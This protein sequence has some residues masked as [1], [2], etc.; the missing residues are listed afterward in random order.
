MA[1]ASVNKKEPLNQC[2]N[3]L[4]IAPYSVWR[5]IAMRKPLMSISRIKPPLAG[6]QYYYSIQKSSHPRFLRKKKFN[7]NGTASVGLI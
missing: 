4:A 7:Q 2:K 3:V 6:D 5:L 1:I